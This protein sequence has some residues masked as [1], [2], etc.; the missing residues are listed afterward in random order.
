[1]A[2]A[3]AFM[4]QACVSRLGKLATSPGPSQVFNV[5]MLKTGDGPVY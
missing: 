4:I 1:M 2:I 3:D 5:G